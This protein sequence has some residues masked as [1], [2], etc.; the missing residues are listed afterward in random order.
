LELIDESLEGF[1]RA[2]VP[3]N[4]RDVDVSF[5]PPERT[6]SAKLNR[7]TVN[8][9][10]WDLRRSVERAR[11][12][13]ETVERNGVLV[14]RPALPRVELRYVV[15]V[16]TSDHR[17]ER[18]LLSGLLR[19]LLA[20]H[21]IPA[22]FLAAGLH[23]LP[24]PVVEMAKA[25]AENLDVPDRLEGQLKAGLHLTVHTAVDTG[26]ATPAGPPAE[27]FEWTFND[28]RYGGRDQ[29]ARRV[30]G[31]ITADGFDGVVVRSPLASAVVSA[32]RFLV[33]ARPGDEI[34]LESDPPRTVVVPD[35][36]G[37]VFSP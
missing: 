13:M 24:A 21:E 33:A 2:T 35:A 5:A 3:L 15:T 18:A 29:L 27:V 9:F 8:V 28:T 11:S 32:G 19:A 25:G 34:I 6:W 14:H 22:P 16:W 20:H 7:P 26:V 4:A 17:D 37:V 10:L 30:A 36:G 23:D 1:L 31:Q 12:G